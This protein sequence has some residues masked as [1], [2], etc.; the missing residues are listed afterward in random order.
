MIL[1]ILYIAE[2]AEKG[3]GVFA[4][5]NITA[6][7]LIEIAPVLVLSENERL[8]AEKTILHDY[9]FEWGENAQEA[10][11]G[12]GYI[13]IY[14]HAIHYNCAYQM[15]FNALTISITTVK[16]IQAGEELFINYNPIGEEEKPVWFNAI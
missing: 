13:S 5:E 9:I 15:D 3:R 14:N 16:N 12:L 6:N 8:L 1:P 11:I 7:T 10:C 4:T 2:T